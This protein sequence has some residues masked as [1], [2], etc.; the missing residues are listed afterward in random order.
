MID[1]KKLDCNASCPGCAAAGREDQQTD[2]VIRGRRLSAAAIVVF[3]VPLII[4]LAG[5]LAAG[6]AETSRLIG[7]AAGF[8]IGVAASIVTARFIKPAGKEAA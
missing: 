8:A 3:L 6:P 2:G 5:L 4:A 7:A 1:P